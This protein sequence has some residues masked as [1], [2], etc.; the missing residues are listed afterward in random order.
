[1]AR[2]DS[3]RAWDGDA[4]SP[5]DTS[6]ARMV[7]GILMSEALAEDGHQHI[8]GHGDPDSGLERVGAG[9]EECLDPQVLLDPLELNDIL[10]INNVLLK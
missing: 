6:Y 10:P 3:A 1:M 7:R 5:L 9:A 2:V 8:N 4:F